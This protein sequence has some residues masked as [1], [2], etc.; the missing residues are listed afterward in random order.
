MKCKEK[1]N[2]KKDIVFPNFT[3]SDPFLCLCCAWLS[4]GP[5]RH[6]LFRWF[7]VIIERSGTMLAC[8]SNVE[9]HSLLWQ[10]KFIGQAESHRSSYKIALSYTNLTI[11]AAWYNPAAI[12]D[13][14][15]CNL[16]C[17]TLQR[18]THT[19]W[20]DARIVGHLC[21]SWVLA[22]EPHAHSHRSKKEE[23]SLIH[24]LL[25]LASSLES[26]EIDKDSITF[27]I[28]ERFD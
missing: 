20:Y 25:G 21:G 24:F 9:A 13:S 3:Q 16:P 1:I 15:S 18:D 27:K 14:I 22:T 2:L 5:S 26:R 11:P 28:A 8:G 17:G 12:F 19:D 10:K 7:R 6:S 4:K 23:A